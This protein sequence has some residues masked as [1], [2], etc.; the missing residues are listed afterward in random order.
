MCVRMLIFFY[1]HMDI[2]ILIHINLCAF[3][4][5]IFEVDS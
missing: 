1:K 5:I 3:G 4:M 2:I